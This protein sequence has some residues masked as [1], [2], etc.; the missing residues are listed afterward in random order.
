MGP[1]PSP[2]MKRES[3]SVAT[4]LEQSNSFVIWLYVDVYMED[5][6]VLYELSQHDV[7]MNLS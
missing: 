3:P 7:S 5:V 1:T 4:I 6:Q 2:M